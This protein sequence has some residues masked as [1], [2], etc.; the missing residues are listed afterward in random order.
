MECQRCQVGEIK[1]HLEVGDVSE[2]G[3]GVS[4]RP[5]QVTMRCENHCVMLANRLLVFIENQTET[6]KKVKV[7]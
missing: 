1:P 2:L 3:N 6:S 7:L 5:L 4:A